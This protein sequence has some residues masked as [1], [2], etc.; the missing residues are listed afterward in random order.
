MDNRNEWYVI[1]VEVIGQWE[2]IRLPLNDLQTY[3]IDEWDN[4]VS[5]QYR[6]ED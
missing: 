5:F 4:N 6:I 2:Q 3:L 1:V